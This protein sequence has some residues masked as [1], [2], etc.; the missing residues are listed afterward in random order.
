MNAVRWAWITSLAWVWGV[1]SVLPTW[2]TADTAVDLFLEELEL[3]EV[4]LGRAAEVMQLIGDPRSRPLLER[5]TAAAELEVRSQARIGLGRLSDPPKL[6]AAT[7]AATPNT[8]EALDRSVLLIYGLFYGLV[9]GPTKR[10]LWTS[11]LLD[12][13]DRDMLHRAAMRAGLELDDWAWLRKM[14]EGPDAKLAGRA[15]TILAGRGDRAALEALQR[16]MQETAIADRP[17]TE[18]TSALRWAEEMPPMVAGGFARVM[19]QAK[20][21]PALSDEAL[22]VAIRF[23]ATGIEVMWHDAFRAAEVPAFQE[24]LV[25]AAMQWYPRVPASVIE[26]LSQHDHVPFRRFGAW[27]QRIDADPTTKDADWRA[28]LEATTA[29]LLRTHPDLF[30]ALLNICLEQDR[31]D[32]DTLSVLSRSS[33]IVLATDG[34]PPIERWRTENAAEAIL[35]RWLV[36]EPTAADQLSGWQHE[37]LIDPGF[38]RWLAYHDLYDMGHCDEELSPTVT[39][40][41]EATQAP[42]DLS[43]RVA[44]WLLK[45]RQGGPARDEPPVNRSELRG[46]SISHPLRVEAI[47]RLCVLEADLMK[48]RGR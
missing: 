32:A 7:I 22:A 38:W 47:W 20:A 30:E 36:H 16:M 25:A 28:A 31:L 46:V 15:A 34:R 19:A 21:N 23:G 2:A 42:G 44:F 48:K 3:A 11:T 4:P 13:S 12:D 33:W 43:E 14:L 37:G 39:R 40:V 41:I 45:S 9:D 24:G 18:A 29:A 27:M 6:D 1:V 26:R 10:Q 35:L 17:T 5:W 8:D